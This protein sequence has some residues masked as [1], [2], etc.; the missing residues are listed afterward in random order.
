MFRQF[1]IRLLMVG[2][3]CGGLIGLTGPVSGAMIQEQ[4]SKTGDGDTPGF[5][6]GFE[7]YGR[8]VTTESG[9]AQRF[10]DQGIQLLYGFNHDGISS[11]RWTAELRGYTSRNYRINSAKC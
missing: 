10:F 7:G 11:A 4:N 6:P 9:D 3:F 8:K 1:A 5:F 2:A